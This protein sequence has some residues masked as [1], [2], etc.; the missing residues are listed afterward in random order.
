MFHSPV[1][2]YL[3]EDGHPTTEEKLTYTPLIDEMPLADAVALGIAE[4]DGTPISPAAVKKAL[5]AAAKPG[6]PSGAK[7]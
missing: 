5:K 3:D 4:K 1:H 6:A 7:E 2:W